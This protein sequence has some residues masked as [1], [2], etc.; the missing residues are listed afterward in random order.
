[1]KW[2]ARSAPRTE[3][4]SRFDF[5]L[6]PIVGA[7]LLAVGPLPLLNRLGL[8]DDLVPMVALAGMVGASLG[9]L[10]VDWRAPDGFDGWGRVAALW[11]GFVLLLPGAAAWE[12]RH[13]GA[14]T[15][16]LPL[17]A[18]GVIFSALPFGRWETLNTRQ[19]LRFSAGFYGLWLAV[20]LAVVPLSPDH[21]G[22]VLAGAYF[23][24]APVAELLRRRL[25][26]TAKGPPVI[27]WSTPYAAA[28]R[29]RFFLFL[30]PLTALASYDFWSTLGEPTAPHFGGV[31]HLVGVPP[32]PAMGMVG[33][34]LL[35]LLPPYLLVTWMRDGLSLRS[36]RGG[37]D[38]LGY[39]LML[40]VVSNGHVLM[41][42]ALAHLVSQGIFHPW[43]DDYP[44]TTL[45]VAVILSAAF[46]VFWYRV[47]LSMD[48]MAA[49]L[50]RSGSR[51][52]R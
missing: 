8:G 14:G 15:G 7:V 9:L 27:D 45:M 18:A 43:M 32:F 22:W 40:Y 23:V 29:R 19:C 17:V 30:V 12:T 1:M 52:G 21:G 41:T 49:P 5:M 4:E 36:L 25:P 47:L 16:T 11:L 50:L 24:S 39:V 51:H 2:G 44:G 20:M 42:L 35:H 38:L 13:E 34:V 48:V 28:R 26:A 31:L 6:P 46:S 33:L 3:R 10:H 37:G